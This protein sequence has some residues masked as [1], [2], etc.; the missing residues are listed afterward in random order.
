M[1]RQPARRQSTQRSRRPD[2]RGLRHRRVRRDTFISARNTR[3]P[4]KTCES[5]RASAREYGLLG[6]N[7]LGSGFSF[8]VKIHRGAGAFVSGESTALMNAIEGHVG[9][10]RPKYIHTSEKRTLGKPS[11]LNNVETWANVPFIINS[12][13]DWFRGMGTKNSKG[14]KIFSL[15]GQGEEHRPG[16]S[17]H[18][19][20]P[21]RDH[22]QNRRR[23]PRRARNSRRCRPAVLPAA[24]IP[25]PC[26]ICRWISTS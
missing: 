19:H 12:G 24:C 1:D 23:R 3:W 16:G 5:H 17:A 8:D 18:G 11:C 26:W 14:T 13:A 22:F 15:V 25:E 7:I 2:H 21:A 9:E 4:R 6:K 20:H 10:P